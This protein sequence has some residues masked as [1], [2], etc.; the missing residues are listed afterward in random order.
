MPT[1]SQLRK[2]PRTLKIFKNKTP[3][4]QGCPQKKGVCIRVFITTPK[5]PNSAQREVARVKLSNRV[6]T[7]AYIPGETHN[8]QQFSIVLVRGGRVKDLPGIRYK[9]IRNKYDLQGLFFRK[10]A[11]SKYGTPIWSKLGLA[12]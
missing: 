11:R 1:I 2:N 4:L 7:T 8:L 10:S 9:M 3:A 12:R 5:K 6:W